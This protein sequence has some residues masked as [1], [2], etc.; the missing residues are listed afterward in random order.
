MTTNM[1]KPSQQKKSP[2]CK[3]VEPHYY[4][5]DPHVFSV[6][7]IHRYQLGFGS[8]MVENLF[9]IEKVICQTVQLERM[10]LNL[11]IFSVH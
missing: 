1:G 9:C 11:D 6:R 8:R 7:H 4:C 2:A 3:I 10:K 5:L